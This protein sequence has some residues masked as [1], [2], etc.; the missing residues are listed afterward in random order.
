MSVLASGAI[1]ICKID[2]VEIAVAPWQW[3]FA[4]NRRAEIERH[5]AA[6]QSER[7]GLW[8]GRVLLLNRYTVTDGVLR[9]TC[10]ET[11]YAS[12][13]TCRDWNFPDGDVFNFFAAAAVQ[14][15]DGAFLLGEMA[16]ST[17]GAG[18]LLFPCGTPDPSDLDDGT[19]DL[20]GSLAR[21]LAEETGIAVASLAAEPGWFLVRDGGLL[22]LIRRLVARE[23]AEALRRHVMRH[24]QS[25]AEPEL[26]D[27]RFVRARADFDPRLARFTAVFLEHVRRQ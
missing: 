2:R 7:P 13:L 21:E 6:R 16:Q 20:A 15:A 12:F 24:L 4:V 10:F 22:A 1:E 18:Q 23:N 8:N 25:E 27:I 5:F 26:S 11:D 14:S 3:N 17:A 19:V 9:G